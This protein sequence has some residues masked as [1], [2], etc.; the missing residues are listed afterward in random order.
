[1]PLPIVP[2]LIIIQIRKQNQLSKYCIYSSLAEIHRIIYM[3]L[4]TD[5]RGQVH[6][7]LPHAKM[8]LKLVKSTQQNLESEHRVEI[9]KK[10]I[11]CP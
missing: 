11:N 10:L 8:K 2:H 7:K 3:V 6:E 4:N 5:F 9:N 1:M